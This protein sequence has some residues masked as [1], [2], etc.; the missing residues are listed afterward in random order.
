[1]AFRRPVERPQWNER[2]RSL[3]RCNIQYSIIISSTMTCRRPGCHHVGARTHQRGITSGHPASTPSDVAWRAETKQDALAHRLK[4]RNSLSIRS[5]TFVYV[6][7]V[8]TICCI[9]PHFIRM[10]SGQKKPI[11][12]QRHQPRHDPIASERLESLA[13]ARS[14][15]MANCFRCS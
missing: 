9:L 14:G 8:V 12:R 7:I 13:Q 6:A 4:V 15:L 11:Q 5:I 2:C 1:M 3:A 10:T